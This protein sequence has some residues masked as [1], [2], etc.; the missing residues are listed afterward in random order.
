MRDRL[1]LSAERT[2]QEIA[3]GEDQDD[4]VLALLSFYEWRA[5]RFAGRAAVLRVLHLADD[6]ADGALG[7]VGELVRQYELAG[8]G[9]VTC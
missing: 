2:D 4:T 8:A 5:I 9:G 3:A 1:G 6:D 7:Y